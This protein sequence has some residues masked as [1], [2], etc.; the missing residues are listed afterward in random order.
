M[1]YHEQG[2]FKFSGNFAPEQ[3]LE[4]WTYGL[5]VRRSNQLSY[6]GI[7]FISLKLFFHFFK[8]ITTFFKKRCKDIGVSNKSAIFVPKNLIIYLFGFR[9]MEI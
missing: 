3:G 2:F 7:F 6:S 8:S 5:T 9:I 1:C 4:P